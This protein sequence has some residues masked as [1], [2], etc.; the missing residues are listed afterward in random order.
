MPAMRTTRRRFLAVTATGLVAGA[1]ST[2]LGENHSPQ[3]IATSSDALPPD[4][5]LEPR[6]RIVLPHGAIAPSTFASFTRLTGVHVTQ[7]LSP[8]D[9]E[10]LIELETT[11]EGR[12]DLV[13]LDES[14]VA[15]GVPLGRFET[16]DRAL[17][18][19][20]G[21]LESPFSNP[22]YDHASRHSIGLDYITV[23]I[24]LAPGVRLAPPAT[25]RGLFALAAISP[26][27][28]TVPDDPATVVGAAL[29]AR[30]HSWNS[31]ASSDLADAG[32][33]LRSVRNSLLV[34]SGS[35][36]A[37]Y[38]SGLATVVTSAEAAAA[39]LRYV[40]PQDGTVA[41]MRSLCIPTGA[42]DPVSAHAWLNHV[43]DP[44]TAAADVTYS[45]RSTPLRGASYLVSPSLLTDE[46]V[47]PSAA[48]LAKIGFATLTP[49]GLADRADLWNS[50]RP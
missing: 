30:G 49:A 35:P 42:S 23:G 41:T 8:G 36:G 24:A 16:L 10:L 4:E 5:V 15:S 13:L 19:N 20:L 48:A 3:T 22:P 7:A 28:V 6:L 43:L 18:P 37:G 50:V 46:T 40:V 32:Q 44:I 31:D 29:V 14:T 45:R 17:L 21:N 25:W 11:L 26:G 47:F 12:V 39:N 33:L 34:R 2:D 1:C 27:A 38:G 9:A